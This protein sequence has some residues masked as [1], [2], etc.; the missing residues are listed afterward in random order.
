[1]LMWAWWISWVGGKMIRWFSFMFI[2]YGRTPES[3]A[4]GVLIAAF[5]GVFVNALNL[6]ADILLIL[7]IRAVM[8]RQ[9]QKFQQLFARA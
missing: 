4:E 2:V 6:A 1:M 3:L 8:R 7:V 9:G 5:M